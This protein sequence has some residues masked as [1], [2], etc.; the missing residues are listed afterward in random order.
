MLRIASLAASLLICAAP[1]IAGD[2][3]KYIIL[4]IADGGGESSWVATRHY[5]GRDM[6][7]DGPEWKKSWVAT[8]ALRHLSRPRPGPDG[9]LQDPSVVYDPAK[10]WDPTPVDGGDEKYPFRF[11]GYKYLRLS[12]PD[13]ANTMTALS[14]GVRTYPGAINVDGNGTPLDTTAHAAKRAGKSVGIISSVPW[15]HATPAAAAGAAHVSRAAYTA[16]ADRI[17]AGGLVD[18]L[19]GAGHPWYAADG[20]KRET[21]KHEFIGTSAWQKLEAGE[22]FGDANITWSMYQDPAQI[23]SL[24]PESTKL[25]VL[26]QAR[27][28]KT[29]QQERPSASDPTQTL[30]G[31]DP[32]ATDVPTLKQM[33]DT[34]LRLLSPDPDG[35]YLMIEGG[36]IDW[37]EH[38]NQCGRMIEEVLAFEE[39]IRSVVSTLD[40]NAN[41]PAKPNW[42][43][44]LVVVTADHD[45]ILL[46]Q[47]S[48]TTPFAPLESKGRGN[49]PGHHW[50]SNGHSNRLIPLYARGPGAE[51]LL[52]CADQLD[53]ATIAGREVGRGNYIQ[54]P[55]IGATLKSFLDSTPTNPPPTTP[56]TR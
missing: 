48:T 23:A 11:E 28:G 3:P 22:P 54:Q 26:L 32:L 51:I 46:G 8:Y 49:L 5:A 53:Q 15:T 40:A 19:G 38:A 21:P 17:L 34:A 31:Q 47:A 2:N 14:T 43:N 44:T 25:P 55:E 6:V 16:L 36:A 20:T 45:H 1:A 24:T 10:A 29:L 41:D 33:A 9:L 13:S 52:T 56:S 37:A 7:I 30:P 27:T 12:A 4:M 50:H 35:F 39:T 42:S 18:V